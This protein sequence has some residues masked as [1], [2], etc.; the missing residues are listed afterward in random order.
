[1]GHD[2]LCHWLLPAPVPLPSHSPSVSG[3]QTLEVSCPLPPAAPRTRPFLLSFT[4]KEES[5][6]TSSGHVPGTAV[7][8][9]GR[10]WMTTKSWAA[11]GLGVPP[12]RH[13]HLPPTGSFPQVSTLRPTC[14]SAVRSV[15]PTPQLAEPSQKLR[16]HCKDQDSEGQGTAGSSRGRQGVAECPTTVS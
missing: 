7:S 2:A 11:A 15:D 9:G 16:E 1:M 13:L 10:L 14:C 4:L 5:L 12:G 6:P 8:T 3:Y